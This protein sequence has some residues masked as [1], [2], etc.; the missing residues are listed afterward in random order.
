MSQR[1]KEVNKL[2][3]IAIAF[4]IG[5]LF[6]MC[7]TCCFVAAGRADR[8]IEQMTVEKLKKEN[9]KSDIS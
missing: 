2:I 1:D 3:E 7:M 4:G 8:E 6:G 5:A 9:D